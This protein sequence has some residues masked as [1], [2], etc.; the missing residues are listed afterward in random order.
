MQGLPDPSLCRAAQLSPRNNG[1][2]YLVGPRQQE[3]PVTHIPVT[4]DVKSAWHKVV[5][6][7]TDPVLIAIVIFCAIGLLITVNV[8]LRVPDFAAVM[9]QFQQYP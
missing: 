1:N 4:N 5:A 8:A 9:G 2:F 3:F 7:M 6:E